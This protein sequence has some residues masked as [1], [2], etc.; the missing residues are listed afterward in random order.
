MPEGNLPVISRS[1]D[2]DLY[3]V[4]VDGDRIQ[5]STGTLLVAS[6]IFSTTADPASPIAGQVWF[7]SDL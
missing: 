5:V 7:R 6:F 2:G 4:T 3:M 1:G